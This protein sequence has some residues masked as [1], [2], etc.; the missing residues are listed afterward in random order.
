VLDA[1]QPSA[2]PEPDPPEFPPPLDVQAG[3]IELIAQCERT[4]D[5]FA[6][7]DPPREAA[8]PDT[9]ISW[10]DGLTPSTYAAAYFPWVLAPDPLRLSGLLLRPVPPS[11]HI[12]GV[13]AR[14]DWEVGVHRAPANEALQLAADVGFRADD[15]IHGDANDANLNVIRP[16]GGR[17]ILIAGARTLAGHAPWRFVNVR[18]LVA[19]IEEAVDEDLAWAVFEPND[20]NLWAEVDRAV[21]GFL[22]DLWRA[23]MLDGA[24]ATEAFDVRCDAETNPP[25]QVDLGRLTCLI[26]LSPPP[27]AEFVVVR[28]TL[29]ADGIEPTGVPGG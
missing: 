24:T 15:R 22:D 9:A 10:R 19:M 27:P 1:T 8:D 6:V 11:G 29:S 13:Y 21:R 18:R 28:V 14:V 4:R 3:Q 25:D 16:Y 23:G 26:G 5:R 7:L 12:A 17:G 2:P 20:A